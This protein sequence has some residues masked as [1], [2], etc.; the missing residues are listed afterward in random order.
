[1]CAVL[2]A[3]VGPSEADVGAGRPWTGLPK[4]EQER[5][6]E[7]GQSRFPVENQ[8]MW[9]EWRSSAD[10]LN[11]PNSCRRACCLVS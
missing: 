9:K 5:K 8:G 10:D 1:M 4:I 2:V 6:R 3:G 11:V 7:S